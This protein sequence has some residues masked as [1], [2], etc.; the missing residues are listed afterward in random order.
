MI[1]DAHSQFLAAIRTTGLTLPDEIITTARF[2]ALAPTANRAMNQAGM[3]C[4]VTASRAA[5][6]DAGARDSLRPG[7]ASPSP[8]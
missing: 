3:Y 1:S 4:T 7:A 5:R 8:K 2:T 6:S